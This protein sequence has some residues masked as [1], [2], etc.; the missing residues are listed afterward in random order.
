MAQSC[1]AAA[2]LA[3][4]DDAVKTIAELF[5][6]NFGLGYQLKAELDLFHE[7]KAE[8]DGNTMLH[9]APVMIANDLAADSQCTDILLALHAKPTKLTADDCAEVVV[10]AGTLVEA[11]C[12][13]VWLVC[14]HC[15]GSVGCFLAV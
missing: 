10:D 4:K 9:S 2:V 11:I 13:V 14:A 6:M 3:D 5:G 1:C 15:A 8:G 7:A 12:D